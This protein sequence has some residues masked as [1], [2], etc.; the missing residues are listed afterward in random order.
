ML[1][2]FTILK[3]ATQAVAF[4]NKATQAVVFPQAWSAVAE[5]MRSYR[6]PRLRKG[7]HLIFFN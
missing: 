5:R 2:K 1:Q 3:K 4:C 6:T 7:H